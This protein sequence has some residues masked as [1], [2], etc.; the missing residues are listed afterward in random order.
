M[1]TPKNAA[2]LLAAGLLVACSNGEPVVKVGKDIGITTSLQDHSPSLTAVSWGGDDESLRLNQSGRGSLSSDYP[3]QQWLF[4]ATSSGYLTLVLSSPERGDFD[5]EV[6]DLD[7]DY[8]DGSW[9]DEPVEQMVIR[10]ISGHQYRITVSR[11]SGSGSY[12]L[13]AAAPSRQVLGMAAKEYLTQITASYAGTC[14]QTNSWSGSSS[15][16]VDSGNLVEYFYI[17]FAEGYVRTLTNQRHRMSRV[18]EREMS[19]W[20]EYSDEQTYRE[21]GVQYRQTF[22][23]RFG[24]DGTFNSNRSRATLTTYEEFTQRTTRV[25]DGAWINELC[26]SDGSGRADFL[27]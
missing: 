3:E 11:Y 13:V 27:L 21:D 23:D 5:I 15:T 9:S 8:N 25:S 4:S 7:G 22:E 14:V 17:N 10:V 20:L 2:A 19:A 6:D 12:R 26:R 18:N 24:F 1:F 16:D